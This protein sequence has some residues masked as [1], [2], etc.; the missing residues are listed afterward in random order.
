MK[1]LVIYH[2]KCP[3]GFGA[4]LSAWMKFKDAADYLPAEHGAYPSPLVTG[5]DVYILDFSFPRPTLEQMRADAKS[6]TILDHHKTAREALHDFPG[7]V[8]DMKKSG[9]RLAWEHFHP[10]APAPLLIQYIED[11]DL[12]NWQFEET[13]RFTAVLDTLPFTFEAWHA[14]YLKSQDP[15]DMRKILADGQTMMVKF[16][17]LAHEQVLGAEPVTVSG[18]TGLKLNAGGRFTDML[19]ELMCARS[20]AFGMLW[21]IQDGM[22]RVSFR[23]AH[24]GIDVSAIAKRFGGGGHAAAASFR[25][26]LK[27]PEFERFFSAYILGAGEGGV[28]GN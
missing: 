26:P 8:F 4:A 3:D 7:A 5:R 12:Y 9:A 13:E 25:I 24:G 18:F 21:R 2:G 10:G 14:F 20:G 16:K 1:T 6:L 19:G 27:T 15:V 23:S 17:A 28:R 11:R 22:L